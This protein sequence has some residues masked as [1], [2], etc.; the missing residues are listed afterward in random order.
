[1]KLTSDL[2]E[3]KEEAKGPRVVVDCNGKNVSYDSLERVK[4]KD[5]RGY[6]VRMFGAI[7]ETDFETGERVEFV[8]RGKRFNSLGESDRLDSPVLDYLGRAYRF[9]EEILK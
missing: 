2:F 4:V 8:W 7:L 9:I 1:M 5:L 3:R 6:E